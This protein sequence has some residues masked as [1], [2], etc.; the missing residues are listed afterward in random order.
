MR[1][2]DFNFVSFLFCFCFTL[3]REWIARNYPC[4]KIA[5][6]KV[7]VRPTPTPTASRYKKVNDANARVKKINPNEMK[8][9]EANNKTLLIF[10]NLL[11]VVLLI[12]FI[13]WE[14]ESRMCCPFGFPWC[15]FSSSSSHFH[16]IRTHTYADI[17]NILLIYLCI[18]FT[19]AMP[20]ATASRS[21]THLVRF[22]YAIN[23]HTLILF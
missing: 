7:R 15:F 11:V 9:N 6:I 13:N 16:F 21:A 4:W 3:R 19:F 1:L 20:S 5:N 22:P 17:Q 8:R 23:M 2:S 12:H 18:I 10:I 14:W